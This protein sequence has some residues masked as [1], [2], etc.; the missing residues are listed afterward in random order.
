MYRA[1]ADV[2]GTIEVESDYFE[3]YGSLYYKSNELFYSGEDSTGTEY[4]LMKPVV[5]GEEKSNIIVD[6]AGVTSTK[7]IGSFDTFVYFCD[8]GNM[9][10][11][12]AYQNGSYSE[13]RYFEIGDSNLHFSQ[14]LTFELSA[15]YMRVSVIAVITIISLF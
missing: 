7:G 9:F 10:A 5:H 3:D 14:M 8:Q 6:I 2:T 12:E 11:V 4:V 1:Q 15:V 13:P